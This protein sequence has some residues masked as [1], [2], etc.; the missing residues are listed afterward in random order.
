MTEASGVP[1]GLAVDG[2]NRHDCKMVEAT[3]DSIP[4]ERP[5]PTEQDSQGMCLDKGYDSSEVRDLVKEFGYTAHIHSRG[6]EA[7]AIKREAGFKARRWVVE[8]THSWM[9]RFRRILTRWEKK[10]ENYLA[11]LHF[12]CAIITFRCSGLFG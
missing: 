4:V 2:A 8:R 6:E 9:N 3:I 11:L 7:Q 5:E 1:I 10:P 12:V